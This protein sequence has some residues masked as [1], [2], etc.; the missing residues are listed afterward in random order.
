MTKEGEPGVGFF[1]IAAGSARVD[2]GGDTKASLGPGDAF[3]EMALI[4]DGTSFSN[5]RRRNGA[6]LPRADSVGLQVIRRGHADGCLGDAA[7]ARPKAAI[8]RSESS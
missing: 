8:Q 3:G 7:G 2:I 5:G 4:D 6:P 1:V